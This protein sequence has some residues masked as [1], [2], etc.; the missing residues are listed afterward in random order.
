MRIPAAIQNYRRPH[1][2]NGL[3]LTMLM[4][5]VALTISQSAFNQSR[6]DWRANIDQVIHETD[7]LSL[8]SQRTFYLNKI[9]KNYDGIKETWHYTMRDGKVIVFQ[10][11]YLLDSVEYSE[12][13]YLNKGSLVYSEEYETV[14]YRGTGDD[15]IKWG[16]IYYFVSN[17]L[18]Q[19]T[20]L[21]KKKSKYFAWNPES[22]TLTRFERRYSELRENIPLTAGR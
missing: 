4:A 22:E 20:T 3:S 15:E 13:Y 2:P 19:R 6:Y 1:Q 16:G 7:S 5:I 14:Y 17:N 9:D 8:Q 21:G 18:R 10:V 12:I 11:R